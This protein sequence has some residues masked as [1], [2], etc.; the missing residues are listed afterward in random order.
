[1]KL[2]VG[3]K[4]FITIV[5]ASIVLGALA[6][7]GLAQAPP[8]KAAESKRGA[9]SL[10]LTPCE[11]PSLKM[12]ARCGKYEVWEDREARTGRKISLNILVFP[13]LAATPKPDPVFYLEGGPGG[14]AVT[15]AKASPL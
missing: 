3:L 11:I 14:S 13:A 12:T 6:Q 4:G 9:P 2:G 15:S 7:S 5:G 1:M 8:A 10:T